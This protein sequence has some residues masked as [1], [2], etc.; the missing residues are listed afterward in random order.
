[1]KDPSIRVWGA[2]TPRT[3]RVYWALHE[4][5]APYENVSIRT[6]TSDMD[7]EDFLSV[8]PGQKIPALE[9]GELTLTESGAIVAYLFERFGPAATF[10]IAERAAIDRWSYFALTELDATSLYVIRRHQGLP[11]IY[12]EAPAAVAAAI[13]YFERQVAVVDRALADK[14]ADE[15]EHIVG[16]TLSAT[17]IHLT[18]CCDWASLCS[19]ELPTT[20]ARYASQQRER[21]AYRAAERANRVS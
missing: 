11:E 13:A 4:F 10:S 16:T 20:L 21:P 8:S 14:L 3:L 7:R 5:A 15:R 9:H 6:R 18:T 19:L 1:M 12:G 2:G 17:D